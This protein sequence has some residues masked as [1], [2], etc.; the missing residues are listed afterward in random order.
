MLSP[1]PGVRAPSDDQ[2]EDVL[3]RWR[4]DTPGCEAV[5]HFNHAGSSLP[6]TP[7]TEA[8][9]EHL[10]AEERYGGYEAAELA[11]E[12][13]DRV[14]SSIATLVGAHAEEIALVENATRA[15]DMAF[16]SIPFRSGDKILTGVAEYASNFLAFLHVSE[17]R[18]V[19][20]VVVPDDESGALDVDALDR[21]IDDRTRLIA[22]THVPT[23]GGLVNPAEQVG[24]IAR[25]HGVLYLLD[26]CQSVGQL[27]MDVDQIG[28]DFLSVTGRKFLRGPRGT[29]FLYARQETTAD[30]HPPLVDLHAATWT[31]RDGY[32][33]R[34]DARRFEN[35]ESY[36]AGRLGLGAAVDYALDVGMDLIEARVRYLAGHLREQL[37]QIPGVTVHDKG[38]RTSGLVTFSHDTVDAAEIQV[39]MRAAGINTSVSR[40]ASTRLDFEQRGLPDL[41]RASVHYLTTEEEI[42]LL[43][44]TLRELAWRNP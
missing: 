42:A 15:W 34:P 9:V 16:Y 35:W 41:V 25:R 10:R 27:A 6:P 3:R 33:L 29:G 12:R 37:N 21:M 14:Y 32:E 26:A 5:V 20:V 17:V 40:A 28:C 2:L 38:H 44:T 4:A 19:E 13:L 7:V 36:I 24:Q 43:A 8:V 30:L 18:N 1:S 39:R 11:A 23:N 22:S 31:S